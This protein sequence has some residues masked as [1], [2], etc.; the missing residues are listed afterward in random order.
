MSLFI[1]EVLVLQSRT[2]I[3]DEYVPGFLIFQAS[4]LQ[5]Y[6]KSIQHMGW[7]LSVEIPAVNGFS[8]YMNRELLQT[9]YFTIFKFDNFL[10]FGFQNL[11]SMQFLPPFWISIKIS[12]CTITE[13]SREVP[14]SLCTG[15]GIDCSLTNN[16]RFYVTGNTEGHILTFSVNFQ[17]S[18]EQFLSD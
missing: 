14:P 6:L 1:T 16:L 10:K 5:C 18:K 11:N 12:I 17:F 8:H 4:T 7:G 13:E 3:C 15:I 2:I 9:D